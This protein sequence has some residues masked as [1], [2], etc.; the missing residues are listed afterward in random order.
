MISL[1]LVLRRS[2]I[3]FYEIPFVGKRRDSFSEIVDE[4]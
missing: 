2:K 4:R 3:F 1:E